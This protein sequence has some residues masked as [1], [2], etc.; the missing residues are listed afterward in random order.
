MP[1]PFSSSLPARLSW[2][3]AS[4]ASVFVSPNS[5]DFDAAYHK[6]LYEDVDT[7]RLEPGPSSAALREKLLAW[8]DG[9]DAAIKG[10]KPRVTPATGDIRL[11]AK[12]A[13]V[14]GATARHLTAAGGITTQEE[15]DSLHAMGIDAVVGMAIYTGTLKLDD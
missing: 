1:M 5:P 7:T 4:R 2:N 12:D 8:R 3:A 15:I 10:H 9:M 14:H 6:R 13:T 11:F